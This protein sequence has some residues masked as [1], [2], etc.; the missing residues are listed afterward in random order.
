MFR[1]MRGDQ[2]L[3]HSPLS[4]LDDGMAIVSGP[5]T[6]STGYGM[7]ASVFRRLSDAIEARSVPADLY[8]ARDALNLR[9][10]G[11]DDEPI[12]TEFMTVYDFGDELDRELEVKLADVEAWRRARGRGAG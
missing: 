2:E 7:V 9:L 11:P 8:A 6:P 5:F 12:S 1:V 10:L 4:A 3:G